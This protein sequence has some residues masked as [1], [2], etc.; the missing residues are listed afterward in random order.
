MK[1]QL[2]PAT[3]EELERFKREHGL[4]DLDDAPVGSESMTLGEFIDATLESH[5]RRQAAKR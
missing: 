3:A 2:T 4:K 1:T 5:R